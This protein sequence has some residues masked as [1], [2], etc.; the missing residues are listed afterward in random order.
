MVHAIT[1]VLIII[2]IFFDYSS[3]H[4]EYLKPIK[5]KKLQ[6]RNTLLNSFLFVFGYNYNYY[7]YI[8]SFLC[9][10]KKSIVNDIALSNTL[11]LHNLHNM[12]SANKTILETDQDFKKLELTN[13]SFN[14]FL[15]FWIQL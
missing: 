6:L 10:F 12:Y 1:N 4:N 15:F 9:L 3:Q 8:F 7:V 14:S 5:I 11:Q 13:T 2:H